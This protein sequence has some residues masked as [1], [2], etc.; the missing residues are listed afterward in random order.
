LWYSKENIITILNNPP[1]P[2]TKTH[3]EIEPDVWDIVEKE[4]DN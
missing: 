2:V 4:E 3:M 1:R